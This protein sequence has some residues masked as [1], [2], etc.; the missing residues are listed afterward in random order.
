M[1][2][3]FCKDCDIIIEGET[4][5]NAETDEELCPYCG[6]PAGGLPED[7]PLEDR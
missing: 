1:S 2:I 7:D 3:S 6:E 5:H 4:I